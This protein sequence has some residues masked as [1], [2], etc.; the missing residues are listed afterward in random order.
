M[1]KIALTVVALSILLAPA[2]FA[3]NS[4]TVSAPGLN[5]TGFALRVNLDDTSNNVYVESQHPTAE[6]HYL[7]R[8]WV[9]PTLLSTLAANTSIRIGGVNSTANGQ[10]IVLFLKHDAPGGAPQFQVNA[11]GMQDAGAPSTFTFLKGVNVGPVTG[12]VPNQVEVEWTRS[13]GAGQANAIFRIQR[14]TPGNVGLNQQLS[15]LTMF[16]FAVDDVRFGVLAGTGTNMT[17][18]GS[19]KFDEFESYR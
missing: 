7:M 9:D 10:R 11:W 16:D 2:A 1:K 19:Y 6:T 14:I 3:A 8:F 18:A 17:A 13:L 12:A 15:N 4:L 5:S